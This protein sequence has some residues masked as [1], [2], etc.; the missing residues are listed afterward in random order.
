MILSQ[1][2]YCGSVALILTEIFQEVAMKLAAIFLLRT[3][4]AIIAA[5]I[6]CQNTAISITRNGLVP[7]LHLLIIAVFCMLVITFSAY[8]Q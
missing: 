5:M 2:I 1:W 6:H 3:S 7:I 8:C 4:L